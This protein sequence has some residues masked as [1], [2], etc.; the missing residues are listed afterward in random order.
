LGVVEDGLSFDLSPSGLETIRH[1]R[2]ESVW[3]Q[4]GVSQGKSFDASRLTVNGP[5]AKSNAGPIPDWQ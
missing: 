1:Q 3:D 4:P 5:F 2:L